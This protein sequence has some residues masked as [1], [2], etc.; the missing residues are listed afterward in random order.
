[1]EQHYSYQL[2][3]SFFI[4][5]LK[6]EMKKLFRNLIPYSVSPRLPILEKGLLNPIK[7]LRKDKSKMLRLN[8]HY[9]NVRKKPILDKI[10]RKKRILEYA[11]SSLMF[12][13]FSFNGM[14]TKCKLI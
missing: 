2:H 5:S 7:W 10:V 3:S 14:I 8:K 9:K 11:K 4:V 12:P 13:V 6:K 1:M